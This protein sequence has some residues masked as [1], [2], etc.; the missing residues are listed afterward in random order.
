MAK[1][2]YEVRLS[3]EERD[4]LTQVVAEGKESERTVMRARVLLYWF[5]RT[6]NAELYGFR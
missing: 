3:E 6:Y 4:L 5:K 1:T 2:I